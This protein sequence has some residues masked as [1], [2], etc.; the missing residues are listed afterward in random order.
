MAKISD[1]EAI[2][3]K[4]VLGEI[5]CKS[6]WEL[7]NQK[8]LKGNPLKAFETCLKRICR[9][10]KFKI[11]RC[12]YYDIIEIYDVIKE[13]EHKNKE[14]LLG[15][16]N[17]LNKICFEK[18][19]NVE[20]VAALIMNKIDYF[21]NMGERGYKSIGAWAKAFGL[22]TEDERVQNRIRNLVEIS[23]KKLQK[24]DFIE[25]DI[26]YMACVSNQHGYI[27]EDEFNKYREQ[28]NKCFKE[29]VGDRISSK[30]RSYYQFQKLYTWKDK[31]ILE[32]VY[33][34]LMNTQ[35]EYVYK[36]YKISPKFKMEYLECEKYSRLLDV[37]W[38][39][40]DYP[41]I[42][43]TSI[44]DKICEFLFKLEGVSDDL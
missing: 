9:F 32:E 2:R 33:W 16:K 31:Y 41:M 28:S 37:I 20:F 12:S 43:N 13:R 35:I 7:D 36:V 3:K 17:K 10:E 44:N 39:E 14:A 4:L 29:A 6:V 1:I 5:E 21:Y 38:G 34:R 42:E 24:L 27:S 26:K 18:G 11:G 23:L 22:I 30:Y 8:K 40:S 19:S 15:N 25:V